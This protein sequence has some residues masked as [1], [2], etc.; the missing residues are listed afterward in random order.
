LY[1]LFASFN[2][3]DIW[4]LELFPQCDNFCFS[5]CNLRMEMDWKQISAVLYIKKQYTCYGMD[6]DTAR[7][8]CVYGLLVVYRVCLS[9]IHDRSLSWHGTGTSINSDGVKYIQARVLQ[10]SQ[11][12]YIQISSFPLQCT[13]NFI[14]LSLFL[15]YAGYDFPF[16]IFKLFLT[17]I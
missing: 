5:F 9:Q 6:W 7:K 1:R 14:V 3:F 17:N 2:D 13:V 15:R 12:C 8:Q 4:F 11:T 10:H 16:D